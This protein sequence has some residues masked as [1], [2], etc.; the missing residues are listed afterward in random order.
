MIKTEVKNAKGKTKSKKGKMCKLN[1]NA[2]AT[3]FLNSRKGTVI[4]K[5]NLVKTLAR[6]TKCSERTA[7]RMVDG[8]IAKNKV[9]VVNLV[10]IN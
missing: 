3:E 4:Q 7:Y 8:Y 9:S 10:K 1:Y 2:K 5:G 6:V